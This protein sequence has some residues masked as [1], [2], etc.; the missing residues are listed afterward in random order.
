[1]SI[2]FNYTASMARGGFYSG[3]IGLF[4]GQMSYRFPPYLRMSVVVN[5]TAI[6]LPAPFEKARFWLLGPKLDLTLSDKVFFSS[7]V[8]YNEQI[9]NMN[10]NLRFQ[11][12]YKPVSDLF[13]VYTGNYFTGDWAARNRALVVKLS[14]WFN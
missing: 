13:V 5:Y 9:D 4:E 12:R 11:W 10:I 2:L 3:N 8:Q 14:Y 6:D 1:M 7:F